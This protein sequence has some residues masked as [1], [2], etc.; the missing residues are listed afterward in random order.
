MNKFES[1]NLESSENEFEEYEDLI[2]QHEDF[3]TQEALKEKVE[4]GPHIKRLE[5]VLDMLS[6]EELLDILNAI[7]TEK[8]A[9]S[10]MERDL[11]EGFLVPLVEKMHFLRDRTDITDKEYDNLHEKYKIISRAVGMINGGLVDHDR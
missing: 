7:E 3:N 5:K 6:R 1:P 9:R 8:E 11:A 10:N 4:C 2:K